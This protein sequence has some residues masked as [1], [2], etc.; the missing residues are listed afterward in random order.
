MTPP[1]PFQAA[2]YALRRSA[3]TVALTGAGASVDSGLPDFR[4]PGGIWDRYPASE[5][6]CL[7]SFL[8]NPAKV[9]T[10]VGE[11]LSTY[12]DV[13]PNDGHRALARLEERGLLQAVITQNIDGLHQAAGSREVIEFHGSL[14][15]LVCL[16]CGKS[17]PSGGEILRKLP[18][19]C[20]C[21]RILKPDFVFF[22]EMIPPLA[23][24]T[25]FELARR[26]QVLLVAGTSA[27]VAPAS[28]IPHAAKEAG[29][30][31]VELNLAPTLLTGRL[32]DHF[33]AG[34]FARVM[35]E[36][37]RLVLE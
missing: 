29:A 37:A 17:Y 19:R 4:S 25:S 6:A 9:W 22:G 16:D 18:P 23:L 32:T 8:A 7:D 20:R 33:L 24:E 34:P 26:C 3:R 13:Q 11:L 28:A 36:L 31:I 5:Y 12:G 27:E 35:P 21:G 10:F 14:R 2:A 30:V 1:T 15:R